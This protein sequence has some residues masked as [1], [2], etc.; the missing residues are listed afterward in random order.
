MSRGQGG[1]EVGG[2]A[3]ECGVC[4]ESKEEGACQEGSSTSP[5]L[6]LGLAR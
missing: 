3:G 5:V 6:L 4:L 2:E 1:E